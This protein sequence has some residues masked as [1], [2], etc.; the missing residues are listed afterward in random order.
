MSLETPFTPGQ[1][2]AHS[3]FIA[4]FT[5]WIPSTT[6]FLSIGQPLQP[7]RVS[8]LHGSNRF[9]QYTFTK[10][11][12]PFRSC[13]WEHWRPQEV[14]SICWTSIDQRITSNLTTTKCG[15]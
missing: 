3:T 15:Q 8:S 12:G 6:I 13:W 7:L 10:R 4:S 14:N 5:Q 2:T 11:L 9:E 1:D